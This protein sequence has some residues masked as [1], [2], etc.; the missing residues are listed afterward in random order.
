[1][2]HTTF[3]FRV[4]VDVVVWRFSFIFTTSSH[5]VFCVSPFKT[6]SLDWLK[7]DKTNETHFSHMSLS[8]YVWMF[9]WL[10]LLFSPSVGLSQQLSVARLLVLVLRPML[11]LRCCCRCTF[12]D[13]RQHQ[14]TDVAVNVINI[15]III[16]I[17]IVSLWSLLLSTS[18]ASA[19]SKHLFNTTDSMRRTE[20]QTD[21]HKTIYDYCH[22]Q[23]DYHD[24]LSSVVQTRTSCVVLIIQT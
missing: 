13:Q 23:S 12:I 5:R 15:N 20:R 8:R 16:I 14:N 1:M 9:G 6:V 4:R 18:L 3:T 21:R 11:T 24:R 19:Q 10:L 7:Y 2:F 22:Y 17:V